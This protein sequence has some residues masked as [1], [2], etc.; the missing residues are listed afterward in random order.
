[1]GTG[2]YRFEKDQLK[3][4]REAVVDSRAGSLLS[5]AIAEVTESGHFRLGQ[6]SRAKVPRGFDPN[7]ERAEFLRHEGLTVTWEGPL[8]QEIGTSAFLDWCETRCEQLL[9]VEQWLTKQVV[10]AG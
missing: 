3:V 9:P 10:G 2:I 5:K 4:F 6:P 7:H 8:P 1:M